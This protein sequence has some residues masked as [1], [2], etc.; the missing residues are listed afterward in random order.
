MKKL[1]IFP[2]IF[3]LSCAKDN[4]S[5]AQNKEDHTTLLKTNDG[6]VFDL[7]RSPVSSNCPEDMV[8]VEGDYCPQVSEVCLRWLDKNTAVSANGGLGPLRC[9]EFEY[10]T[11]CLSKK[12]QRLHFCI[13]RLEFPNIEGSFPEVGFD[14]YGAKDRCAS[15]GKRLCEENEWNFAAEGPDVNPYI[16]GYTRPVNECN[17]DKP[18]IDYT[19]YKRSEWWMIYQGVRSDSNSK[20]KSVFGVIDLNGNIDEIINRPNGK[21]PYRNELTGGY[22]SV[23]RGRVRPKTK[24]HSDLFSDYQL[25]TR[26]CSN[27]NK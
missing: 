9:A 1:F 5:S 14:W 20:C 12:R 8:E 10:P 23:M 3:F 24:V 26:C 22:W 6:E 13:D 2:I 21:T 15:V 17:I 25:G 16:T 11:K 7:V 19:K 4:H 18:W 27:I